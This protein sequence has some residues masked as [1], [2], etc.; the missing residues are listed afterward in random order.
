M[1]MIHVK[2][3]ARVKAYLFATKL[4]G[5]TLISPFTYAVIS[6]PFGMVI[7]LPLMKRNKGAAGKKMIDV[8]TIAPVIF[9]VLPPPLVSL[10]ARKAIF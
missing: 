10:T 3:P 7:S 8:A 9:P 1:R 5:F 4:S 6:V 2:S